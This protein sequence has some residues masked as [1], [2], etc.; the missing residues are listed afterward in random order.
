MLEQLLSVL[1]ANNGWMPFDE[2][3][4]AARDAGVNPVLWRRA[5]MSG[6]IEARIND[7][8]IHELRIAP[9]GS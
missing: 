6:K 5:K 3:V 1:P 8:G 4:A 9:N 2:F 7:A